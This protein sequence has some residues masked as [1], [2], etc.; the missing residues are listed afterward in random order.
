[1]RENYLHLNYNEKTKTLKINLEVESRLLEDEKI[2]DDNHNGIIS[3]KELRAH[4]AYL[5][6]YT[7]KHFKL[8]DAQKPL[9]LEGASLI[10]H[11]YQDQTY[12]TVSKSFFHIDL[13]TLQLKYSMFFELEKNHKLLIHLDDNR[14]DYIL[15]T[16]QRVYNFSSYKITFFQRLKVFIKNG[17]YHI[18]DGLDHLLFVLMILIPSIVH[19]Q[20]KSQTI[21]ATLLD[22]LKIVTTFSLAHSIT[23]FISGIGFYKP[24]VPLIESVIAVS[25]FIVAFMNFRA[26]YKHVNKKIVFVFG[27]VHGFGFANVLE[28]AKINSTAEFL[29]ALFGFNLGVEIG[30]IFVILLVLPFLYLL[31]KSKFC[32]PTLKLIALFAM[33]ISAYWFFQRV[34]LF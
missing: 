24:S 19:L 22:I 26:Q 12:M 13:D 6:A 20:Q 29:T 15:N 31:T 33:V 14:G 17:I 34:G 11:R 32:I 18:L 28:I 16:T 25:I 3:Y 27:L 30:Q 5:F 7:K 10:F 21:K 8:Y 1:M 23:L 2:L 9:S 4:K